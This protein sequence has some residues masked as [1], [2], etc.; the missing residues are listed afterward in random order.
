NKE[1]TR[2]TITI[3]N[4]NSP[5]SKRS[6]EWE[7]KA[8]NNKELLLN[9]GKAVIV[10]QRV[11]QQP[12]AVVK[13]TTEPEPFEVVKFVRSNSIKELLAYAQQCGHTY[14]SST[15]DGKTEYK[16]AAP[17]QYG[18]ETIVDAK[19]EGLVV[20]YKFKS[21]EQRR[22]YMTKLKEQEYLTVPISNSS[23]SSHKDGVKI[24]M[25]V[26]MLTWI[27]SKDEK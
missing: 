21:S 15:K 23:V 8:V 20:V 5:D 16:A 6:T 26:G 22:E 13:K 18:M 10:M 27:I 2:L 7:I 24:W 12:E 14:T 3:T 19:S 25:T 17:F 1:E 9:M 11:V 4:P